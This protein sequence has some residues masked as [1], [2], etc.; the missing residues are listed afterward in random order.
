MFPNLVKYINS[1]EQEVSSISES[2]IQILDDLAVFIR[3]KLRAGEQANLIFI[4]THNSR[5][6]QLAQ[7]WAATMAHYYDVDG[8]QAFSGGTEVTAFHLNAIEALKQAGFAIQTTEENN[9]AC[10]I[11]MDEND[12]LL[13]CF[14]KRFDHPVNPSNEFAA[15]MTCSEA[16][17]NCPF[18]SGA[19]KRVPLPY[20]DPKKADGSPRE[21]EIYNRRCRQI[22]SEMKYLISNFRA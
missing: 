7:V 10:R 22:A 3:S 15:V 21:A 13:R 1:L 16:D 9:P 5:R 14:S 8:I 12:Q 2:R 6:S 17:Q 4:C 11:F 19:V 20:D 18:I